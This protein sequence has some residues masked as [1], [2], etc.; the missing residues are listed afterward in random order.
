MGLACE[1]KGSIT[2]EHRETLA[3]M[4]LIESGFA[5]RLAAEKRRTITAYIK[6]F[7]GTRTMHGPHLDEEHTR[8]MSEIYNSEIRNIIKTFSARAKAKHKKSLRGEK[9]D[10]FRHLEM[11]W[12]SLYGTRKIVTASQTTIKDIKKAIGKAAEMQETVPETIARIRSV[13]V[14][15]EYRSQVIAQ[16]E[17]HSAAIF[18]GIETDR[19]E[20]QG[21]G[22]QIE[23]A[24]LP[25]EDDRTRP[26]HMEVSPANFIPDRA[27]F[28]IGG[29]S[30]DYPGDPKGSARNVINCRCLLITQAVPDRV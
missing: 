28:V 16:T 24:W 2:D 27:H 1:H 11:M 26:W 15:S 18:A 5:R 7:L 8:R 3:L 22:V 20:A 10:A 17:T 6:L 13:S 19:M 29:E 9:G 25:T 30:M 21:S 12:N 14:L 23:K 4:R